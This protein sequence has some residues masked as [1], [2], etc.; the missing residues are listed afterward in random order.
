MTGANSFIF[1]TKKKA[2]ARMLAL[3]TRSS[4]RSMP[5]VATDVETRTPSRKDSTVSC[6]NSL[7]MR[8][9]TRL[10]NPM[11]SFWTMNSRI[12][13]TLLSVKSNCQR[14][15]LSTLAARKTMTASA[16]SGMETP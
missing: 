15:A 2:M 8:T 9:G 12:V 1:G 13:E 10:F 16:T 11:P 7:A 14:T 5:R 3:A 4:T 6:A